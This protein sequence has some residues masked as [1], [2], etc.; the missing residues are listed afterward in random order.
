M[1]CGKS[2]L[3]VQEAA[4]KWQAE[5]KTPRPRQRRRISMIPAEVG[6]CLKA[7]DAPSLFT[8]ENREACEADKVQ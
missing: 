1:A 3:L 2:Y 7:V 8:Q 6:R 4:V 5:R